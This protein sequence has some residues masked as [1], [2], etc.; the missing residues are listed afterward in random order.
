[1]DRR[2]LFSGFGAVAIAS[3]AA[4]PMIARG[5]APGT[6][7][8][9]ALAGT[10][11]QGNALAPIVAAD[12]MVY[13]AS[14]QSDGNSAIYAVNAATGKAAWHTQPSGLIPYAAGP[15]AVYGFQLTAGGAKTSVVALSAASGK[16]LWTYQAGDMLNDAGEGSLTYADGKIFI[17]AGTSDTFGSIANDVIALDAGTGRA[18]WKLSS[19]TEQSPAVANGVVYAVDGHQVVALN[20]ATGTRIWQTE[21][22]NAQSGIEDTP[23]GD[24]VI[25]ADTV[26]GWT[27]GSAFALDATTGRQLWHSSSGIPL[28]AAVGI[29]FLTEL[30]AFGKSVGGTLHAVYARTG[31]TAWTHNFGQNLTGLAAAHGTLYLGLGDTVTAFTATTY[32]SRWTYHL[33]APATGIALAGSTVYAIDTHGM[34]YALQE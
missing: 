5:R 34:A 30:D 16:S 15:G 4:G 18:L 17:G 21:I 24:L 33:S 23:T 25:T 14:A 11:Y 31:A 22:G 20:S 26:I 12:G 9:Q 7:L 1:M 13:A 28:F 6:L 32:H 19:N 27:L 10:G 29:V 3:L 2:Q 8:W